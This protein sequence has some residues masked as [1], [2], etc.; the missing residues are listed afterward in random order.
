MSDMAKQANRMKFGE[1]EEETMNG[2]GLGMI[3]KDGVGG[4]LRI[5]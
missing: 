5:L 4:R 1:K 2:E 3:G